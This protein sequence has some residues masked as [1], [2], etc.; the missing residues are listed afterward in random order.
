[1][2]R[3]HLCPSSTPRL[4]RD[5]FGRRASPSG[6]GLLLD[7]AE[8]VAGL[9]TAP[10]RDAQRRWSWPDQDRP[11]SAWRGSVSHAGELGL[12]ALARG[13]WIG[14]DIQDQRPRPA[15]L[16]WLARVLDRP[17]E[18]VGMREWAET[19]ALLK[20][21]G[22][23]AIRPE[24]VEL[25]AW[26]PGWRRTPCGWWLRSSRPVPGGVQLAL[27]AEEPLPLRWAGD[28]GPTG[29]LALSRTLA[30]T[31]APVRLRLTEGSL[32]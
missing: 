21:K 31:D 6:R 27:A 5:G 19:E 10:T 14:V 11:E 24:R 9:R 22:I 8:R 3:I 4:P 16:G 30:P 13:I 20:A 12:T 32:A 26:R 17:A 25:P 7:A 2:S 15:A 1:M 29:P 18:Q 23:A 28:L